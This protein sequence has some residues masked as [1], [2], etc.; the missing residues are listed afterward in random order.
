MERK[1]EDEYQIKQDD[2]KKTLGKGAF[3][4]VFR[5]YNKKSQEVF[6]AKK[7]LIPRN[8]ELLNYVEQEIKNLEL[9]NKDRDKD[10][11]N[12]GVIKFYDHF[13]RDEPKEPNNVEKI[14]I[15]EICEDCN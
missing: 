5:C 3:G 6:A 9:V 12:H 14:F 11:T 10:S 1:F 4:E 8:S 13:T 7:L 2:L 15:F